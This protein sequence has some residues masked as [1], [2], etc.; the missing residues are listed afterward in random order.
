MD[1]LADPDIEQVSVM[2]CAQVFK[3]ETLLNFI[4]FCVDHDPS[5]LMVVVPRDEDIGEWSGI[6]C[7]GMIDTTPA[8]TRHTTGKEDDLAGHIFELDRMFIKF[9]TSNSPAALASTPI[10]YVLF[11]EVD[12]YPA[13]SGKEADPIRLGRERTRAF[14]T[15][16]IV[17][18]STP[19]VE[20][21]TIN[22]EFQK[23]DKRRY[24]VPCPQCGVYQV[25]FFGDKTAPVPLSPRGRVR[26]P[27]G[28][29]PD[30]IRMDRLAW[31]ECGACHARVDE[32][33]KTWMIERGV[34]CPEGCS[35]DI[36]GRIQGEIPRTTHRGYQ[37]SALYAPWIKRSWSVI[38]AEFLECKDDP[39]LLLGWVNSTM[40][41][42]WRNDVKQSKKEDLNRLIGGY[43]IGEVPPGALILTAAVDV[44][45]DYFLWSITGWGYRMESWLIRYG[46]SDTL[47]D[48]IEDVLRTSYPTASGKTKHVRLCGIDSG[49][50]TQRVYDIVRLLNQKYPGR[51]VALKGDE[52]IP[53]YEFTKATIDRDREGRPF[54]E[55]VVLYRLDVSKLKDQLARYLAA[56]P[57]DAGVMHMPNGTDDGYLAHMTSEAKQSVR[58]KRTKKVTE[59]WIHV[60][61]E[62]HYWDCSVYNLALAKILGVDKHRPQGEAKVYELKKPTQLKAVADQQAE[63]ERPAARESSRLSMFNR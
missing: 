30:Q 55:G 27:E 26:W 40:G 17:L 61:G 31:Y 9:A 49:N 6:R 46:R 47:E 54:G 32:A 53:I 60:S 19:T 29:T 8:L 59:Q 14:P 1:S 23:S 10:R 12:K 35:V 56:N 13:F 50:D 22:S 15:G 39:G 3:T 5:P 4:G 11:D 44:Q 45:K 43:E 21:G 36:S 62:N 25:L 34:W 28:V 16:K 42:P 57:G 18:A 58:N 51:V 37:L 52:S 38:A 24:W 48:L 41:E 33:H 7:K 20:T 63:R 2:A